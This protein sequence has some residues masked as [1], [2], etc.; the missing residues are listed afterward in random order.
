M[1]KSLLTQLLKVSFHIMRNE[2]PYTEFGTMIEFLCGDMGLS[3]T[4]SYNNDK[5]AKVFGHILAQ[6]MSDNV[7]KHV[8]ET[9]FFSWMIDGSAAAKKRLTYEAELVYIQTA[10]NLKPQTELLSFA[11]MKDYASV[12]AEAILHALILR[13]LSLDGKAEQYNQT[14]P[15]EVSLQDL[16]TKW[17]ESDLRKMLVLLQ[18]EPQSILATTEVL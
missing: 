12:N 15:D 5:S 10:S 3:I 2:R 7:Q 16:L 17:N 1:A 9:N 6:Q 11:P 18:M 14:N 8:R 13:L 4:S